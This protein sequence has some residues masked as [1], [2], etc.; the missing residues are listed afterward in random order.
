[1]TWRSVNE[2]LP[3]SSKLVL[4]WNKYDEYSLQSFYQCCPICKQE[5]HFN[6][7]NECSDLDTVTHWTYLPPTPMKKEPKIRTGK[8]KKLSSKFNTSIKSKST[9]N[10]WA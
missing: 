1:M 8:Q 7:G 9:F 10:F 3:S 5:D 4:T 6:N 2:S